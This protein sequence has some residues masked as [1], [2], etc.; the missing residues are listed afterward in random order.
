MSE[1]KNASLKDIY[2]AAAELPEGDRAALAGL[3]LSGLDDAGDSGIEAAWEEELAK[4][5]SEIHEGSVQTVP[6]AEVREQL[7]DRRRGVSR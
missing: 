4:R 1:F 2:E 6:W 7:F 3:L 5:S